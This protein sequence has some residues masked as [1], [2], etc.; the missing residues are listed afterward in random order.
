MVMYL[1]IL[2]WQWLLAFA[3]AP[4]KGGQPAPIWVQMMPMV[5][6]IVIFYFLLIRPQQKKAREHEALVKSLKSG[7]RVVTNGGLIAV[8]VTVKEKTLTI[9]S[10]D[11]KL[12]ISKSAVA[13]ILAASDEQK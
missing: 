6:L 1:D 9:R 2:N 11:S 3:P 8:V 5:F 12:E 4:S 13:E 7:D 10:G